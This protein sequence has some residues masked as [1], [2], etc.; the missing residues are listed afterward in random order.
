MNTK[1]LREYLKVAP[2]SHALWRAIE[3]NAFAAVRLHR[4]ILDVGCGFGEFAGVF[5]KSRVEMGIDISRQFLLQAYEGK[6]YH[7]LLVADAREMPFADNSFSSI[8]SVSVFEHIPNLEKAIT[9]CYRVLTPGGRLVF[10]TPSDEFTS[11]LFWVRLCNKIGLKL[12]GQAYGRE[13]NRVFVHINLWS[14]E[15]WRRILR[16][17]GF[18]IEVI[19]PIMSVPA[20]TFWDLGLVLASVSQLNKKLFGRR[21]LV[22]SPLIIRFW[23]RRLTPLLANDHIKEHINLF[24]VARKHG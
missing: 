13:I 2:A 18:T 4:P 5:F 6:K 21:T 16:S 12:L 11:N 7:K 24:I 22:K 1:Y 3:T 9:E 19:K 17:A 15:R 14:P 23:E 10:T 20:L 8:V